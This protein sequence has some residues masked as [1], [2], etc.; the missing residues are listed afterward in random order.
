MVKI[1]LITVFEVQPL[2][3]YAF[4][5]LDVELKDVD[6]AS[7]EKIGSL[8]AEAISR[9]GEDWKKKIH[10]RCSN[11]L[12]VDSCEHPV[13]LEQPVNF[14]H[15]TVRGFLRDQYIR[16]LE[17]VVNTHFVPPISLCRIFLFF[18]KKQYQH[19]LNTKRQYNSMMGLVDELLYCAREAENHEL[20]EHQHASPVADILDQVDAVNTLLMKKSRAV[21]NH[22]IHARDPPAPRGLGEYNEG[23]RHNWIAL[24]IQARLVKYMRDIGGK[25]WPA[26]KEWP[27]TA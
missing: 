18:L 17:A 4:Y 3:L 8:E 19:N 26:A 10:T 15:R 11:L 20:Y 14:L 1:F 12:I 22:W 16:Q 21:R 24:T 13:F 5:L 2:P 23:H 27:A 9:V 25:G 6:Y 7:K